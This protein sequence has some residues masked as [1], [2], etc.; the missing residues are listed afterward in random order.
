MAFSTK[1]KN[2][3]KT[4]SRSRSRS[5]KNRTRKNMRGGGNNTM[6]PSGNVKKNLAFFEKLQSKAKT[7][8]HLFNQNFANKF[9]NWTEEYETHFG[10]EF[11]PQK[12][13]SK[14]ETN[15]PKK[16][17]IIRP[18]FNNLNPNNNNGYLNVTTNNVS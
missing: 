8:K 1:R 18:N 14:I 4:K 10:S 9:S 17:K 5:R 7:N 12:S 6:P 3:S 13:E 16:S 11:K 15:N 2:S